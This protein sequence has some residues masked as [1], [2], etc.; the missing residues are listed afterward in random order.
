MMN[1][2]KAF[3]VTFDKS[4]RRYVIYA[5]R[6][7]GHAKSGAWQSLQEHDF[8]PPY[9]FTD[10]RAKRLP[11]LDNEAQKYAGLR[12]PVVMGWRDGNDSWGSTHEHQA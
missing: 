9:Q 7:R 11:M 4:P 2:P 1:E 5:A 10:I 6:N 8:K 12:G 3:I